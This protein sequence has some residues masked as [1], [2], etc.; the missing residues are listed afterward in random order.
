MP[1]HVRYLKEARKL[2]DALV[3][4]INSDASVA[5]L[6]G[7]GRPAYPESDRAEILCALEAVDRVVVFSEKRASRTIEAIHP[8]IYAKGGTTRRTV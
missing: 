6:K 1:V 2:G 5:E 4:A 8:H 3:V 7:P